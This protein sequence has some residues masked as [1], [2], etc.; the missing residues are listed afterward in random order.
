[1]WPDTLSTPP[2]CC[3]LSIDFIS[4]FIGGVSFFVSHA[5]C[6]APR[7]TDSRRPT[8]SDT[9]RGICFSFIYSS[10]VSS[11]RQTLHT[12]TPTVSA[13]TLSMLPSRRAAV[14][15][16]LNLIS[17]QLIFWFSQ[18]IAATFMGVQADGMGYVGSLN[19]LWHLLCALLTFRLSCLDGRQPDA[20]TRQWARHPHRAPFWPLTMPPINATSTSNQTCGATA[21]SFRHLCDDI[22]HPVAKRIV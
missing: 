1:M 12:Q 2:C 10:L 8:V 22:K 3:Q 19:T 18:K 9:H 13:T 15:A 5:W 11:Y 14:A 17:C 20:Q 16:T 4:V 7:N 21:A 6:T